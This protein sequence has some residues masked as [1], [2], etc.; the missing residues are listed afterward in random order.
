VEN[1]LDVFE[2]VFFSMLALLA[3]QVVSGFASDRDVARRRPLQRARWR[4]WAGLWKRAG[5]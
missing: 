4:S 2:L 3:S 1:P 5:R